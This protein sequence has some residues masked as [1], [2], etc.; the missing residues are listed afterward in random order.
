MIDERTTDGK[1][2]KRGICMPRIVFLGNPDLAMPSLTA[3]AG[4][5]DVILVVTNPDRPAGRKRRHQPT[6][7]KQEAERLGLN[8]FQPPTLRSR[9]AIRYIAACRPDFLVV[10]AYGEILRRAVLEIPRIAP[11]NAHA[12]LLPRHRGPSPITAA[13]LS[14]DRETGVSTMRMTREMDAGPIYLQRKVPVEPDDTALSLTTRLA[15][16]A[17]ALLVETILG[18]I[19]GNIREERQQGEPTYTSMIGKEDGLIDWQSPAVQIERTIRAYYPWPGAFTYFPAKKGRR[20]ALKLVLAKVL[21]EQVTAVPGSVVEAST[22]E[23]NH[24]QHLLVA[25]GDSLLEVLELQ[26]E[27]SRR[28]TSAEFLRGHRMPC[29][30]RLG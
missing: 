16:A 27:G 26:P 25:A 24:E 22:A 8:V 9:K 3:L 11:V 21:E 29:G 28:M 15:P 19:D 18:I 7:V 1:Q 23:E 20:K 12:S 13:I 5:F 2:P 6:P 30:T 17:A 14:G 4:V 10:V